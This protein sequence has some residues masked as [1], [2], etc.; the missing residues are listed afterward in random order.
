MLWLSL[1]HHP[2]RTVA[3]RSPRG[4]GRRPC[5]P[6]QRPLH[7]CLLRGR[8]RRKRPRRRHP[9]SSPEKGSPHVTHLTE[10]G[11]SR[12]RDRRPLRTGGRPQGL[13]LLPRQHPPGPDQ[14]ARVLISP[15]SYC[16]RLCHIKLTQPFFIIS[17]SPL[18]CHT[19]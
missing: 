4:D 3:L 17:S 19:P 1:L 6:L 2:R 18:C 8:S 16:K 12:C 10:A 5:P 14:T 13:P 9:H 11:L 7:R 15:P